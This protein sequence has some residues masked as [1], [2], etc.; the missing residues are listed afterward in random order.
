MPATLLP[1]GVITHHLI[2]PRSVPH[3]QGAGRHAPRRALP[4]IGDL[5]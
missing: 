1:L 5:A 3:I 2:T 4:D